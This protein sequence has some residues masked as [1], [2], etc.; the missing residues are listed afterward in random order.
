VT[1]HMH[2]KKGSLNWLAHW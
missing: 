1:D 2:N